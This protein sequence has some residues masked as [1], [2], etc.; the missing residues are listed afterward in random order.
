MERNLGYPQ[1]TV[2]S[3]GGGSPK[4]SIAHS[5]S[6][7]RPQVARACGPTPQAGLPPLTHVEQI[8]L[9][10]VL[11]PQGLRVVQ[12]LRVDIQMVL[13]VS[14]APGVRLH[15][16]IPGLGWDWGVRGA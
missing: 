12:T 1:E 13:V 16:A 9:G 4:G 15:I 11:G 3:H 14:G 8:L 2:G 10:A 6:P 7:T 5:P